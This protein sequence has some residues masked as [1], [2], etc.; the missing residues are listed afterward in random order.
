MKKILSLFILFVALNTS[1]QTTIIDSILSGGIYRSYRLYVPADY[2]GSSARPLVFNLHGYTSNAQSQQLYANFMP[3]ADTANFLVVHPQGTKDNNNQPFWNAGISS[4]IVNDIQFLSN[5]ID[6]IKA[7]YNIDLNAVYSCGMSNGGY[8]SQTLACEL[9]NRIAAI[10]SVTGSI[11]TTQYGTNC[12]PTRPVPMMQI[13]GTA[14]GTVPY[15]GSSSSMPIDSVVKYWVRYNQCNATPNFSNVPNSNLTD[16]CTAEHYIYPNGLSG[17]SVELYKVIGGG[18]TWP[19]A[20]VNIGVTNQDFS[21][22]KEIWRFFRKYKL[23]QLTSIN[24]VKQANSAISVFPNPTESDIHLLAELTQTQELN[25]EIYDL[26]GKLIQS[27]HVDGK[28]ISTNALPKGMYLLIVKQ[29][30]AF[31]GS[32]KLVKN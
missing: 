29:Q 31:V 5:L 22:S 16:G 15:T 21:A 28:T 32:C 19:G 3:I 6:S 7:N 11:F 1:A 30:N 24:E 8:M 9:S 26:F 14:D 10:A 4:L 20:L 17:S 12:H 27:G 2:N 18:H 25:Y 13:S 23:N